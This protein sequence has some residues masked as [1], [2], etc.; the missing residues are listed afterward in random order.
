MNIE[1]IR[2]FCI[3]KKGSTEEFPFDENTLVFKVLGKMFLMAPLDKWE[4]GEATLPGFS[5]VVKSAVK[6]GEFVA[7]K[8]QD[9]ILL[10]NIS[11]IYKTNK[12]FES[13]GSVQ[14]YSKDSDLNTAFPVK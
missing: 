3:A 13:A 1:Q 8:T 12:Y 7:V 9:G 4:Q 6:R 5:F 11:N 14:E 2:D 10:A